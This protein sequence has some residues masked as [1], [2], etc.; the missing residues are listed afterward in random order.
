M[1]AM[2]GYSGYIPL[3]SLH[4]KFNERVTGCD[5]VTTTGAGYVLPVGK[6]TILG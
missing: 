2:L 3:P 4:V 6:R 5:T 1:G